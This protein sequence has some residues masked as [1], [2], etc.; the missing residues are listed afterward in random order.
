MTQTEGRSQ[1]RKKCKKM[2]SWPFLKSIDVA[3]VV[4]VD[5]WLKG[6]GFGNDPVRI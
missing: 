5:K 1:A 2:F 3:V 4:A 6:D